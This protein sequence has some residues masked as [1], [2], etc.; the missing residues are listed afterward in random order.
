[1]YRIYC[2]KSYYEIRKKRY[3]VLGRQKLLALDALFCLQSSKN[4]I[5]YSLGF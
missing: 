4:N 5:K 3:V 2:G 1:M